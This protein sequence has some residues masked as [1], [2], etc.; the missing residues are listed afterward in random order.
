M[1]E[2]LYYDKYVT[3]PALQ[4]C[5][6]MLTSTALIF[7]GLLDSFDCWKKF[8]F[9]SKQSSIIYRIAGFLIKIFTNWHFPDFRGEIF[10]NR[11]GL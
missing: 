9:F 5:L 10:M 1:Y 6:S 2:C 7:V 4:I 8:N 3:L 11:H